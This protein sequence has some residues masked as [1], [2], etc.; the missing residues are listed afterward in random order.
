MKCLL[1]LLT[2]AIS[3]SPAAISAEPAECTVNVLQWNIHIGIDMTG[4]FNLRQQADLILKSGAD[5][6]AL[7]EVDKNCLRTGNVDMAKELAALTGMYHQFG[8]AR[9]LPPEGLYG[10]AILSRYPIKMIGAW[11][12]PAT[13]DETRGM[14]LV[15]IRAPQPFYV[16][17]THLSYRQAENEN[18]VKAMQFIMQ[19][20]KQFAVDHPIILIGD[21]NCKPDSDP[22]KVLN[23]NNWVLAQVLNTFPAPAAR[24]PLDYLAYPANDK[25]LTVIQ[26]AVI[27]EKNAS[28]H[29]PVMN[30]IKITGK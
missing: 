21:F 16:A 23:N 30:I 10:N 25:R 2:L 6:V 14:L 24:K 15:L 3:W 22:I 4:K 19:I 18:R 1:L 29:L 27:D 12:V 7:N 20:I 13:L 28:D 17:V 26:R 8:G 11:L 5:V 9:V